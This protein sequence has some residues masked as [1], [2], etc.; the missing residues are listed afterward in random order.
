[1]LDCVMLREGREVVSIT[2]NLGHRCQM[3]LQQDDTK[4]PSRLHVKDLWFN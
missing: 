1:M 2:P 3:R 4:D